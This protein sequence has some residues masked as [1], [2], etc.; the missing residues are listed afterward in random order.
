MISDAIQVNLFNPE[1]GQIMATQQLTSPMAV[2][3]PINNLTYNSS[4]LSDVRAV[5]LFLYR[6]DSTE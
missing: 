2:M 4:Y 5:I 1:T 3:V 6:Y